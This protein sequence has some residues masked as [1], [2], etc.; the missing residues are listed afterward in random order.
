MDDALN[1]IAS[2]VLGIDSLENRGYYEEVRVS[3]ERVR[4][5]LEAAYTAGAIARAQDASMDRR[6]GCVRVDMFR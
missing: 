1:T 5:A 4:R 3:K 2:E 6:I